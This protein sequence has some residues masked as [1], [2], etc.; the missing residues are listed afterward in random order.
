MNE[1]A[2]KVA[3]FSIARPVPGVKLVAGLDMAGRP[4]V[5]L[6]AWSAGHGGMD[7][8][9]AHAAILGVTLMRLSMEV[10]GTT[11]VLLQAC[12]PRGGQ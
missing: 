11:D 1:H 10:T 5:V 9:P 6:D 4:L 3:G 2:T 8:S 12:E 7:L